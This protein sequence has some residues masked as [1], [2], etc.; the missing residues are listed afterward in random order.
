MKKDLNYLN[1]KWWYRLI[2]VSFVFLF[3][4]SFILPVVGIIFKNTPKFDNSESYV[5][6]ANGKKFILNQHDFSDSFAWRSDKEKAENICFDGVIKFRDMGNSRGFLSGFM[7]SEIVSE[8]ENSG[9]YELIS[10][11]TKTNW[12]NMIVM[13]LLSLALTIIVF[14]F[15]RRLFYYIVLGSFLPEKPKKYLFFKMIYKD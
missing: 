14:E 15:I 5:K 8:T 10:K 4:L 13:S 7:T 6:C 12:F 3:L 1:S 11:Y 9:K 2:K